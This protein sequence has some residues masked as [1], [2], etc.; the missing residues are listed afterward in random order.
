MTQSR[1]VSFHALDTSALHNARLVGTLR[2]GVY[3][4]FRLRPNGAETNKLDVTSGDDAL[5][6]LLTAQG[7]RIEETED[8]IGN[9]VIGNADPNL[10]RIDLIV[11]SYQFTT[12]NSVEAEYVVIRGSYPASS[13]IDPT[14][15]DPTYSYQVPIAYVRVR[16][17][18]SSGGGSRARIEVTDIVHIGRAG[19]TRAPENISSFMPI[20]EPA[21]R[22]RLFVHAGI[23]PSFDGTRTLTFGGAHSEPIDATTM[24]DGESKYFLFGVNDD[25]EVT[26]IGSSST[27]AGLP[28][29]TRDV[30]PVCYVTGTKIPTTD[31]ITLTD[32]V[33]VRFPFARQL[34]P[35]IEEE[36]YKATLAD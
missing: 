36:A 8:L 14:P 33:D 22:R 2:P 18:R 24:S 19:D 16:S 12:D 30:F 13:A 28:D 31:V 17:Q 4:G 15:P 35:V 6:I 32:I 11:A 3:S 9:I 1:S 34:S 29:F 20:I 21:D 5:S 25:G 27:V 7:V 26:V 10:D 23:L